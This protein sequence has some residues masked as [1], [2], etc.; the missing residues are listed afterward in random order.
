MEIQKYI[1]QIKNLYADLLLF[2]QKE[3]YD[4]DAFKQ[5]INNI[6][7]NKIQDNRDEIENYLRLIINICN[8][9]NR[10]PGFFDRIKQILQFFEED[11]K[12]SFSNS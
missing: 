6:Q 12:K 2:I 8:N 11:I 9:H 4:S 1:D 5:I 3:E 7:T 10:N